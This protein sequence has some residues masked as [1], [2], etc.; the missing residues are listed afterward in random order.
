VLRAHFLRLRGGALAAI[1]AGSVA[2]IAPSLAIGSG[3][4]VATTGSDVPTGSKAKLSHG[5]AI[6]PAGAPRKVVKAINAANKIRKKPYVWGGGHGSWKA[7]GYDCSGAVSYM[8][9]GGKML[10][11]PLA[12]GALSH[13]G[14]G[15]KGKW[16]TVY[17]NGG[18]AYAVVAGLRWDTS[19]DSHGTGPRW[20]KDLRSNGGFKV[21]H[22]HGY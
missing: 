17:A 13:W 7:R 9:H 16:I 5:E 6:A 8:L 18:H 20:H 11:S 19:G 2:L 12:S 4:G 22:P 10:K 15:G 21:R 1:A 3:G 14:T